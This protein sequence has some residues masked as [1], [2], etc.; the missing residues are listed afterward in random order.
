MEINQYLIIN[1]DFKLINDKQLNLDL[2]L[3]QL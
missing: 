2:G 3:N 1:M